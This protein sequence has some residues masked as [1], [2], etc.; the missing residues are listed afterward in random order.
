MYVAQGCRCFP[1]RVANTNY[2][3]AREDRRRARAPWI[4]KYIQET[5]EWYVMNY[6][7]REQDE[8]RTRSQAEAYERREAFNTLAALE[9]EQPP[10][11]ATPAQVRAVVR[12]LRRLQEAG[13]GLNRIAAATTISRTRLLELVNDCSYNQDRPRKRR[14]KLATAERILETLAGRVR[15]AGAA[16][17]DARETLR[18]IEELLGAG[19]RRYEIAR[20]LGLDNARSL[21]VK[22]PRV[23]QRTADAVKELHD[24]AY[25]G[26]SRLRAVCRCPDWAPDR[27]LRP[28]P[29]PT[30]P[31]R[32]LQAALREVWERERRPQAGSDA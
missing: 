4:V 8:Y 28:P 19:L 29:S 22:G 31:P 1:C 25:R 27:E 32:N 26:S 21:Q 16:V 11:W 18:L 24:L 17:V 2:Q 15:P 13:V 3:T 12:H 14:L 30:D 6:L 23:L 9:S 7:T 5:G 10:L 20:G